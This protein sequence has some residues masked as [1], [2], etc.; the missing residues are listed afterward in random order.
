MKKKKLKYLICV[1]KIRNFS[2]LCTSICC[3]VLLYFTI[4]YDLFFFTP[5][6]FLQWDSCIFIRFYAI[7]LIIKKMQKIKQ[8]DAL[9]NKIKLTL[10]A[11]AC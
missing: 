9:T 4:K 2:C 11:F 5:F 3:Y 1:L 6:C 10:H 7:I 8:P